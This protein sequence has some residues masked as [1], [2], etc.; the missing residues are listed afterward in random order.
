[1]GYGGAADRL[2]IEPGILALRGVHHKLNAVAFNQVDHIRAAL[3][4]F[5]NTF[6]RKTRIFQNA[7]SSMSSHD[8]ETKF[9]EAMSELHQP[10]LVA[11]GNADKNC[12]AGRQRL[13]GGE[14]SLSKG[15]AKALTDSHHFTG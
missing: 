5:I 6:H 8:V 11:I 15:F 4:D 12:S 7:C 13:P 3:F 9:R 14:L 10:T 2:F 1:M